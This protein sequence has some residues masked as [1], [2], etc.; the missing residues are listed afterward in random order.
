MPD[1]DIRVKDVEVRYGRLKAI[2]G[3]DLELRS[4]EAVGLL[5]AN[6]TDLCAERVLELREARD[7]EGEQQVNERRGAARDDEQPL[8]PRVVAE[9]GRAR[10]L[11]VV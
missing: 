2:R 11:F 8:G 6:G 7:E 5:G 1:H 10:V 3:I 4:G 9:E